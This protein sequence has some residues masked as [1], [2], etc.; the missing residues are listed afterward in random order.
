MYEMKAFVN[1]PL[2]VYPKSHPALLELLIIEPARSQLLLWQK[3]K[4]FS[5]LARCVGKVEKILQ[6]DKVLF[7]SVHEEIA[8]NSTSK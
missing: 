8:V 6:A 2:E 7:S 3:F 4:S 5:G 1:Q